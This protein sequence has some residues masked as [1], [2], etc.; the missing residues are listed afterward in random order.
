MPTDTSNAEAV[1]EY[2]IKG[3]KVVLSSQTYGPI[4][5]ITNK[6]LRVA[7]MYAANRGVKWMG[8]ASVDRMAY[9][10]ARNTA[11]QF[12]LSHTPTADGIMWVDS[13]IKP[14][15]DRIARLLDTAN[16]N[17]LDFVSGLY[18]QREGVH[19]PVFHAWNDNLNCF[20]PAETYP[21]DTLGIASGCGFGFVYTSL[22]MMRK[23]AALP[24]FDPNNGWFP[25]RRDVGG[26]GEDLSFCWMAKEAGYKLWIDTG[27]IVEHEANA[28][29][30]NEE[31]FKREQAAWI[32][33]NKEPLKPMK[34]GKG[35]A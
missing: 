10:A 13:D 35:D 4:N 16:H 11:T 3:M 1:Q 17:K 14:D 33:Q 28:Q 5:P 32:A 9:G 19:N 6:H 30:I 20:Q 15:A 21:P 22:D 2:D 25:D 27:V 23:V 34:W 24:D 31:D 7:I 18:F 12:A 26:H 8:D 29:Y